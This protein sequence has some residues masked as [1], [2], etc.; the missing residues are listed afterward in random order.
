MSTTGRRFGLLRVAWDQALDE[1]LARVAASHPQLRP[2]H[3][4]LFRFDGVDGATTAELAAHAGMTKQSMHELVTH[5]ERLSYVVRRAEP[6]SA[7]SRPLHLTGS[8]RALE[9]QVHEAIAD[10]LDEWRD[11]L[12]AGRFDLLWELL[13]EITAAAGTPPEVAEIRRRA[14]RSSHP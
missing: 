9:R 4:L 13:R 1:V 10:V 6:G 12:G 11:R 8:G 3:L 7:R 14:Q 2:A 5:L